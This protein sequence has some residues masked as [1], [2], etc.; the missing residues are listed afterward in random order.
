M[1]TNKNTNINLQLNSYVFCQ[2]IYLLLTKIESGTINASVYRQI[3][4]IENYTFI[5]LFTIIQFKDNL[6]FIRILQFS[7]YFNMNILRGQNSKK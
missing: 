6:R 1:I 4:V 5:L 3:T 7:K 2:K